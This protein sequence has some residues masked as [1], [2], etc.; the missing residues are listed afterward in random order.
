[1]AL[2]SVGRDN[3]YG[4]PSPLLIAELARLGIPARR[5]DVDGDIA[6]VPDGPRLVAVVRA[7]RTGNAS[8]FVGAARG[9]PSD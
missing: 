1:L 9:P 8:R 2:V 5:T 7:T 4:H 6:V 3:D